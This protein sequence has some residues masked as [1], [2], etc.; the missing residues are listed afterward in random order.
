VNLAEKDSQRQEDKTHFK[1]G[2]ANTLTVQEVVKRRKDFN[3]SAESIK[4]L[5][6]PQATYLGGG[7]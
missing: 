4:S 5:S 2:E 7:G 3:T 1:R 6:C